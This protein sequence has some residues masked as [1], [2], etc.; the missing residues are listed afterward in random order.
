MVKG[1]RS[2]SRLDRFTPGKISVLI[3]LE[4]RCV[5]ERLHTIDKRKKVFVTGIRTL[6]HPVRSHVTISTILSSLLIDS[7]GLYRDMIYGTAG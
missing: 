3:E 2:A 1:E 6:Y 5:L 7:T 4:V